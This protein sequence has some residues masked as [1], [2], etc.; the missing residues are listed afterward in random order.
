MEHRVSHDDGFSFEFSKSVWLLNGSRVLI[1]HICPLVSI[2]TQYLVVGEGVDHK[3]LWLG[4]RASRPPLTP[5]G[6]SLGYA[7]KTRHPGAGGSIAV[8]SP[9]S[10][11]EELFP[12]GDFRR[13]R[14]TASAQPIDLRSIPAMQ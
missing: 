12:N 2:R 7:R 5:G 6:V 14:R 13:Q 11:R 10:R 3:G 1:V 9:Q 8:S 4:C